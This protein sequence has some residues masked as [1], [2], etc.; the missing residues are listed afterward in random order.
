MEKSLKS[1]TI[2]GLFWRFGEKLLTQG[3]S[4]IVSI[5]LA[6]RLFPEDYALIALVS[7][8]LSI[9]NEFIT[10]GFPA[11][12]IQ[13]K[14]AE[15]VDFST[16]FFFSLG[17]S[18]CIYILLFLCAP[19]LA[20]FYS[21]YDSELLINV[22]RV[23][24]L[25]L[26]ITAVNSV[27]HAY[28]SR[29]LQF[30]RYF[31]SS[32]E[33]TAISA[34]IGIWMAYM[35]YGVWALVLQFLVD[36]FIDMTV[37]WFTV[38]WRPKLLFSRKSLGD[39]WA[40]GKK[41]FA[42]S[43]IATVYNNLCGLTIGRFYKPENLAYYEKGHSI[44]SVASSTINSTV[45]S[46]LFPTMSKKQTDKTVIKEM[47]SLS[48]R[49]GSYIVMPILFGLA[50]TSESI[51][52]ILLTE[53][54]LPSVFYMQI[55]CFSFAFSLV[56]IESLQTIKALGRSDIVLK[57]E[58]VKKIIGLGLIILAIPFGVEMIALSVL[59]NSIIFALLNLYPNRVL[60]G[61]S[62]KD[63]WND[64]SSPLI[65]SSIMFFMVSAMKY[66][67]LNM[68][69]TLILQIITGTVIYITLSVI[70]KVK[71]FLYLCQEVKSFI[72][73]LKGRK[74]DES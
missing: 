23:M 51:I 50:A 30:K 74:S 21:K 46:V 19:V 13:K 28:V 8:F 22:I 52:E 42:T 64:F 4:F 18:I 15:E 53:K 65:L 26:I 17:V 38:R 6:R 48:I 62:F 44:P 69:I 54:W 67:P 55:F 35:G 14:E 68:Y 3:V 60:I 66:I 39:A 32:F 11:A 29:T 25:K 7:V 37:L 20:K 58:I 27:Q 5:I 34:I 10:S 56:E 59:I 33:G 40:Y 73:R 47:L 57:L 71:A 41:L 70:F 72:K 1:R 63:L 43:F 61:Y 45:D 31:W 24:G 49:C 9:C 36:G 12:L 16:I 2:S